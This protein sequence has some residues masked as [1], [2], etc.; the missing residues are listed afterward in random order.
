MSESSCTIALTYLELAALPFGLGTCWAGFVQMA[1]MSPSIQEFLNLPE[2][3]QSFGAMMIGYPEFEY[4]RI[5]LRKMD[6]TWH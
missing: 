5:P 3:H 1:V 4:H 2:G 6:I